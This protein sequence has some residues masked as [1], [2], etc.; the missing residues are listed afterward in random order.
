M[1]NPL[2]RL[3]IRQAE[4]TGVEYDAAVAE[5]NAY[6]RNNAEAIA[7]LIDAAESTVTWIVPSD[8][9]QREVL[10]DLRAALAKLTEG[11]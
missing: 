7:D 11:K 10:N 8:K 6:M 1:T 9:N 3:W 2:K 4:T 5:T